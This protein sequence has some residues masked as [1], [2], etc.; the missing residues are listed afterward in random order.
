MTSRINMTARG[1]KT[2]R[3]AAENSPGSPRMTSRV[4]A[5]GP[6]SVSTHHL[7]LQLDL[8]RGQ[9]E[10]SH[11][12]IAELRVTL[13]DQDESK[14]EVNESDVLSELAKVRKERDDLKAA[15]QLHLTEIAHLKHQEK[16][17][18]EIASS[19]EIVT[20]QLDNVHNE[21]DDL[22]AR[23]VTL[24]KKASEEE[25]KINQ[26]K[27]LLKHFF[28]DDG[29]VTLV[30]CAEN[31][32]QNTRDLETQ[33]NKK[34]TEVAKLQLSLE[35]L[36]KQLRDASITPE[37]DTWEGEE[38]ILPNQVEVLL[39]IGDFSIINSCKEAE[40]RHVY[41]RLF[42]REKTLFAVNGENKRLSQHLIQL[43]KRIAEEVSDFSIPV[44]EFKTFDQLCKGLFDDYPSECDSARGSIESH[45]RD[46]S[47]SQLDS[48]LS[49]IKA[50]RKQ[51]AITQSLVNERSISLKHYAWLAME[52]NLVA[53]DFEMKSIVGDVA[54]EI[55]L[56]FAE[57]DEEIFTKDQAIL[58]RCTEIATL[59]E[60][61]VE[62]HSQ[63]VDCG[64]KP[65][66]PATK[67]AVFAI[68]TRQHN[69]KELEERKK[70]LQRLHVRQA[71]VES[72]LSDTKQQIEKKE[73]EQPKI[74][75]KP[76][77]TPRESKIDLLR[78]RSKQ[79]KLENT[80]ALISTQQTAQ[81]MEID[82]LSRL[83]ESSDV[84]L[85]NQKEMELDAELSVAKNLRT[86]Y[87]Q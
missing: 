6:G 32:K 68:E 57:R 43:S 7:R 21:N 69:A 41:Q 25:L 72:D 26:Q 75:V 47:R 49:L 37:I 84:F 86:K 85:K 3:M 39:D 1:M 80:L 83:K 71:S 60:G 31:V 50:L 62:L 10:E 15:Q 9:L 63:L 66:R 34:T 35:V 19:L 74:N 18:E 76:L 56:A 53:P 28:R 17:G 44:F 42:Q 13:E 22:R 77:S 52:N 87:T 65:C 45:P 38:G 36:R 67:L 54:S 79:E 14:N 51:N 82:L 20:D 27:E 64:H 2:S 48:L 40:L 73:K 55:R 4:P 12:E 16:S 81:E 8:L 61:M 46:A 11:Q 5:Q 70:A 29:S 23:A 30:H 59:E 33:L 24:E 78:L 58:Q